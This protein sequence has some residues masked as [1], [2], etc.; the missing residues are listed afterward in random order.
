MHVLNDLERPRFRARQQPPTHRP[1]AMPSSDAFYKVIGIA[2]IVALVL[3]I[4]LL[5]IFG[6][7]PG[8]AMVIVAAILGIIAWV[9]EVTAACTLSPCTLLWMQPRQCSP[10]LTRSVLYG[11]RTRA[12]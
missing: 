11:C 7:G 6:P 4:P 2:S 3:D 1:A 9:L 8:D 12:W 10:R 5:L